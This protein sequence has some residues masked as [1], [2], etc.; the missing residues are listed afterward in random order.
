MDVAIGS[1]SIGDEERVAVE[2]VLRSGQLAQGDE[3]AA[4]EAEIARDLSATQRAVA[5]ASG[6]AAL[7][8]ALQAIGIGPGDEVVTTPFTFAATAS[9]VLRR[10]ARV[11]FADVGDDLTL[12]PES[13]AAVATKRTRLIV[14]VHLYGLPAD[15]DAL[16]DI[17]PVL[18][19]AAQA[20]L[21]ELR[22]RR[23]G[24]L[25]VA[26][27][28]SFYASKNMTTGEGGAVTTNDTG[29]ADRIAMLRNHGMAG[30]Y[31]YLTVATNLRMTEMAAAI[32]RVQLQKL[33]R[34]TELRRRNAHL[35]TTALADLPSV[36]LPIVPPD[37]LHAWH[38]F[39][40]RL[41]PSIDRGSVVEKMTANGVEA[42]VYYPEILAD[43]PAFRWHPCVDVSA[44]LD[45]ARS[46]AKSVLSLPVHPGVSD[47][48]V[49]RIADA[50][51]EAVASAGGST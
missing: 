3:V 44:P 45:V 12:D 29:L 48:D 4:F 39:T 36:R 20:H 28:F 9:A 41:D 23:A 11:V 13:V 47:V 14:P 18:E 17:A 50:L 43:A 46:A 27:C 2:R 7:E 8:L 6:T 40:I 34:M 10:G 19:D 32:G 51:R 42:R 1:T 33:P 15:V 21:A 24:G 26:G 35:L 38:Q 22:G 30:R 5:V 16:G 25:G 49:A 37:R 31:E